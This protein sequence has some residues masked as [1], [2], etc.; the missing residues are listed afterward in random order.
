MHAKR[1]ARLLVGQ[2]GVCCAC[3]LTVIACNVHGSGTDA[4][5]N[6]P[7]VTCSVDGSGNPLFSSSASGTF[8]GG[9]LAGR[10]CNG[11]A[12]AYLEQT[13]YGGL[14]FLAGNNVN[15]LPGEDFRFDKPADATDGSLSIMLGVG[16]P[17]PGTY[18]N[19]GSCGTSAFC[20]SL[21]VPPSVDCGA[22]GA[23]PPGCSLTGPMLGPTCTPTV[24]EICYGAKGSSDC[25]QSAK[26]SGSWVLRLTAVDSGEDAGGSVR[27]VT[28]GT[29]A[30]TM[31]NSDGG[32][33]TVDLSLKF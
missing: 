28:H 27:F 16:S 3:T 9:S 23:C 29:L 19:S 31:V 26:P 7:P 22:S 10:I 12:Y 6:E 4:G 2:R 25:L 30:T 15:V 13:P 5:T 14:V 33:E 20:V 11:G 18:T 8:S 1:D 17:A 24:P 32:A 21:P